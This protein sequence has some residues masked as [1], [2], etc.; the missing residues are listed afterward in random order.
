MLTVPVNPELTMLR[1][2]TPIEEFVEP[3]RI[4]RAFGIAE[5]EKACEGTIKVIVAM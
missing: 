2:E 5:T 4:V 1:V 3:L